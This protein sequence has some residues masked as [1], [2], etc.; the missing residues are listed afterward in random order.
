MCVYT[1]SVSLRLSLSL[2]LSLSTTLF[3]YSSIPL[4]LSLFISLS[5]SLSFP[6][7]IHTGAQARAHTHK[8]LFINCLVPTIC[9]LHRFKIFSGSLSSLKHSSIQMYLLAGFSGYVYLFHHVLSYTIL[10]CLFR[11]CFFYLHK[12]HKFFLIFLNNEPKLLPIQ[13]QII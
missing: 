5:L 12:L 10:P 9:H 4:S 11:L 13:Q 8:L 7:Y 3:L 2:P 6:L 1:P